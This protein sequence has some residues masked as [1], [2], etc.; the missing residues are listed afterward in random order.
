MN[1][2]INE[3]CVE[4]PDGA[5]LGQALDAKGISISGIATA[6]NGKV[7]ASGLRD[8]HVLADG[9]DIVIIKAFYGG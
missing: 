2:R 1:V 5:T 4:L 7:V 3:V 8:S 9:D 6:V